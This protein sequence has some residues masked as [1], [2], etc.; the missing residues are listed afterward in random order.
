[1]AHKLSGETSGL[2]LGRLLDVADAP[3][4]LKG[5]GLKAHT[6]IVGQSG[7]GKSFMLGRLLEEIVAKSKAGILILDPNSDFVRFSE[8]ERDSWIKHKAEF[9]RSDSMSAFLR[10]WKPVTFD[11]LTRR[12]LAALHL[13]NNKARVTLPTLSWG[14]KIAYEAATELGFDTKTDVEEVFVLESV[15]AREDRWDKPEPFK[16][17]VKR[18]YKKYEAASGSD[19]AARRVYLRAVEMEDLRVWS[20]GSEPSSV[21]NGVHSLFETKSPRR[22]LCVDL[23]SLE[24]QD[25][26]LIVTYAALDKLWTSAREQ[27]FNA[28]KR[29]PD[30]DKRRPVFVVIDEAHNL[31]P[32]ATSSALA[33]SVSDMLA[34]IATEGR[35]YGIFLVMVTQRPSRLDETLRTQ[36]DNLCLLKINDRHD[37]RLIEN[38]FGFVPQG[39]AQ[40]A[41]AFKQGDVLLAGGLI[42]RPVFAHAAP[43]R[44]AEGGRNL[45][46]DAWLPSARKRH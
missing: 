30:S 43:R 18:A 20:S 24:K 11:V 14:Q 15:L 38:S 40:R 29:K 44:T 12:S 17:F 19:L 28:I 5:S 22:V 3:V 9:D 16:D 36:C 6:L 46:D 13:E 37:L 23:A 7:S 21:R 33:R 26:R 42:E 32:T 39:W 35:K 2:H 45:R 41:M 34:R 31:A 25:E 1:M 10:K 27:W 8:V 4:L